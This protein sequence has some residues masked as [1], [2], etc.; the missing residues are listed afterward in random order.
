[1]DKKPD[2]DAMN[3]HEQAV[4][5]RETWVR[6][7]EHETGEHGI[8]LDEHEELVTLR[9]H[10][11]QLRVEAEHAQAEREHLLIQMRDANEKLIVET[12]AADALAVVE[13]D[14]RQR[15]EERVA[16]LDV[17]ERE[18]RTLANTVPMLAWFAE[19]DGDVAWY[20]ERWYEYTGTS[21]PEQVGWQWRSVHDP[22][23]LPRVVSKWQAALASGEPWEDT[24]RLRRRDG[25]WR[26]FLGRAQPLRDDHGT[27]IRWFGTYADI[28]AQ[29]RAEH[30]ALASSRVK[31]EFLAMLGHELRNPLA[32]IVSALDLIAARGGHDAYEREHTIIQRQVTHLSRLVDDL[33]DVARFTSGKVDLRLEPIEIFEVIA[34]AVE[35]VRPLLDGNA[36]HLTVDVAPTGLVVEG[37]PMRL[38]QAICN[39]LVN[40]AKYTPKRGEIRVAAVRDGSSVVVRI[41]DNGLGISPEMLPRV[42]EL[43]SQERQALD[44][45]R[46]GLGLG[47]AI[48]QQLVGLHHGHVSVRSEGL[49]H[50]SE[51]TIVL[52]ESRLPQL[53]RRPRDS[54]QVT[55]LAT[56]PK[57]LVVDDN[58]DAAELLGAWLVQLGHDVRV[59]LD[60][61]T[62]LTIAVGFLPDVVLLDLGLPGMDGYEVAVRMREALGLHPVHFIALTGY[63]QPKDRHHTEAAGFDA[64]L[65]KP[66]NLATIQ[67][68]IQAATRP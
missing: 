59:A 56:A 41:S 27:I 13:A 68:S 38:A 8:L 36:Q 46:G 60:G 10:A 30:E 31:D 15:A 55:P 40:A 9:E 48:V 53:R 1:M 47:L 14:G 18:L 33:L 43:F 42:F 7:R 17:K 32:P 20:N 23:D 67:A 62:A 22:A 11:V 61:P 24:F 28:D 44:R 16:R 57:V 26:W 51:F 6:T 63:G 5:N 4:S 39:V 58:V 50:G 3:V 2:S 45:S 64:H 37:D 34:R 66:V 49:G 29:K 21:L 25:V 35:M 19:P 52:P 65:V 12:L 54:H